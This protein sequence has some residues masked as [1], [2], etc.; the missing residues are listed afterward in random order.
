MSEKIWGSTS[1]SHHNNGKWQTEIIRDGDEPTWFYFESLCVLADYFAN[2]S[3]RLSGMHDYL[4]LRLLAYSMEQSWEAN[5]FS[6][7]QE[8]P[9][10]CGTC[11]FI[12]AF[13]NARHLS[14][15]WASSIQPIPPH[16][17]SWRSILIL[18]SHLHL[19]HPSGL[20]PSGSPT[21]T[22]YTH[23]LS[24]I[25]TTCP[26]HLITPKQYWVRNTF[27]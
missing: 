5:Q 3:P 23:L 25:C 9:H 16:S 22:L 6:A 7:S 2:P 12:T 15:S 17:T 10:F 8:S 19:Y 27:L 11:R 24:P 18:S 14:L 20:F 4:I 1:T 13:T 26:T 21:K